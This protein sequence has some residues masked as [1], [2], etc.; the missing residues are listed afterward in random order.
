MS[1]I[2]DRNLG[3]CIQSVK[4][5]SSHG[6]RLLVITGRGEIGILIWCEL[7]IHLH[8]LSLRVLLRHLVLH[9]VSARWSILVDLTGLLNKLALPVA[10]QSIRHFVAFV[11]FTVSRCKR[12]LVGLRELRDGRL[13]NMLPLL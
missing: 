12:Q 5:L 4:C 13:L 2:F 7:V 3:L 11:N 1:L 6:I 10:L 9:H 8:G